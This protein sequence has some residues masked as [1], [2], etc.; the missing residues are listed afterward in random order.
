MDDS[1]SEQFGECL[2]ELKR[3]LRHLH[4]SQLVPLVALLS[5]AVLLAKDNGKDGLLGQRVL[6]L[7]CAFW[8]QWYGTRLKDCMHK[9]G[10]TDK[11]DSFAHA[12]VVHRRREAAMLVPT[13]VSTKL[14]HVGLWSVANLR[15]MT[16]AF[17][18]TFADCRE[19]TL[20][21][22]VPPPA[23]SGDAPGYRGFFRQK[24]LASIVKFVADNGSEHYVC[25]SVGNIV[26]S[27]EGPS[28]FTW[29]YNAKLR[30]WLVARE[31]EAPLPSLVLVHPR[32]SRRREDLT[33][34]ADDSHSRRVMDP[35][36]TLRDEVAKLMADDHCF[37]AVLGTGG[38]KQNKK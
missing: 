10:H 27:S 14:Q 9:G 12:Y 35:A 19:A 16:N 31:A 8:R 26:G 22:L 20:C 25:P 18:C 4:R 38:W 5:R 28:L 11:W 37:D 15:D 30:Q 34:F 17:S 13:E 33:T 1:C 2:A 24:F 23:E 29:A 32:G 3:F 7:Y 6:H 21:E 36:S